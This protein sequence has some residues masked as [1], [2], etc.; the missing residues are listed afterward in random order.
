[1]VWDYNSTERIAD[2]SFNA[3]IILI[4]NLISYDIK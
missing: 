4:L 2:D 1:M 3:V